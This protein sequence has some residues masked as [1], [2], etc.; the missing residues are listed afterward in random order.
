MRGRRDRRTPPSFLS[1][2]RFP[3][4]LIHS[5]L[6]LDNLHFTLFS[7]H[8]S[9][10]MS[11]HEYKMTLVTAPFLPFPLCAVLPPLFTIS[12][13]LRFFFFFPHLIFLGSGSGQGDRETD[14]PCNTTFPL[15]P[16]L[17]CP[18][19]VVHCNHLFT[20][21]FPPYLSVQVTVK[22]IERRMTPL[23]VTLTPSLPFPLCAGLPTLFTIITYSHYFFHLI[24]LGSGDGQRYKRY[25]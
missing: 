18:S 23:Y 8:F 2:W 20:S 6:V 17:C 15:F 19:H 21:F 24:F 1:L 5:H 14:D 9:V 11:V 16:P 25:R 22:E 7:P 3:S 13:F 4:C 10:R 12:T